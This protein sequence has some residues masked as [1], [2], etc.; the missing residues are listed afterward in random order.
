MRL[1]KANTIC[2]REVK[3]FIISEEREYIPFPFYLSSPYIIS[4]SLILNS[5]AQII[6]YVAE[7]LTESYYTIK[8]GIE[9]IKSID[10]ESRR[11][12]FTLLPKYLYRW[13]NKSA[14]N[15]CSIAYRMHY[16]KL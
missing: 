6:E 12:A 11:R 16:M 13:A 3:S 2:D 8:I 15:F 9:S 7:I 5:L 4:H 1:E 14:Y 10:W